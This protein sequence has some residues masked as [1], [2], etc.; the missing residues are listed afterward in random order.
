[1]ISSRRC[2]AI[3]VAALMIS[4]PG[5]IRSDEVGS[6]WFTDF[7]KAH[8]RAQELQCPLLIHFFAHWCAPCQM[9]E[10]Q[11][12]HHPEVTTN[13]GK[14]IVAVKVLQPQNPELSRKFGIQALPTDIVIDP[15]GKVVWRN[16]SFVNRSR[17]VQLLARVMQEYRPHSG[18]ASTAT[19][20][21]RW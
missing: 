8:Q 3:V 1:M 13:L 9:M 16:E 12:L 19:V 6:P 2:L 21:W 11:V 17:Y 20:P 18:S 15:S 4:T 7:E 5:D 10:R 14:R